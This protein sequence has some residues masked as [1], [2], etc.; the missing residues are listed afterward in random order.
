[1]DVLTELNGVFR[2]VFEDNKLV[3]TRETT[4]NDVDM[5][6][7]IAHMIL[8]SAVE[9]K[10]GIRFALGELPTLQNVGDMLD[11]IEKKRVK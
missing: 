8:I 4:A 10:F 6:D 5:W 11:I 2:E 7:S 3:V 1:M 9:Q